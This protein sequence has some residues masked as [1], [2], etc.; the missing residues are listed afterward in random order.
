MRV[1]YENNNAGD[2][3]MWLFL[4]HAKQD[5]NQSKESLYTKYP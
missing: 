2:K 5:K 1:Y 3:D 4:W